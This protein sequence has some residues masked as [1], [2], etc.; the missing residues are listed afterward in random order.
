MWLSILGALCIGLSLGLLGSGGSILTVPVLVYVLHHDG[1]VSIAESLAIVGGIATATAIPYGRLRQIHWRSVVFFGLPGMAGTFGGANL[2]K[3][4]PGPVQLILFA[5]VM[6]LAAWL[7][8]RTRQ[9]V[10]VEVVSAREPPTRETLAV[11]EEGAKSTG[12][13]QNNLHHQS[14]WKIGIEGFTVGVVTGL[15]GVGGGFLI[16]PALV[17]L[18]RLSIRMAVGTS[19]VIIALKS[20]TGFAKYYDVLSEMGKSVDWSTIGWFIVLGILGSLVGKQLGTKLD[21]LTLTRVFATFLVVM[22]G[23]V[24]SQE[25]PK[26]F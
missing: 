9:P 18:G 6:L 7:M 14:P 10:E 26:L 21:Q 15:V 8:F 12:P 1:K 22:S 20:F 23:F 4:I 25:I 5:V 13:R 19:L 24:L 11:A 17:L 3:I 2:A 16:V